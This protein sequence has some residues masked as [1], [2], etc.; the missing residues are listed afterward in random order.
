[1]KVNV[2]QKDNKTLPWVYKKPK[3]YSDKVKDEALNYNRFDVALYKHF[4]KKLEKMLQS[5]S[6]D[7]HDEV[8][9]FKDL[10]L[11]VANMCRLA[12]ENKT[13]LVLPKL[14]SGSMFTEFNLTTKECDHMTFEEKDI[15][16]LNRANQVEKYSNKT[17]R[18]NAYFRWIDLLGYRLDENG[19]PVKKKKGE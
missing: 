19:R 3:D 12:A 6:K 14:I 8:K 1:M 18:S 4:R 10:K 11:K 13:E 16:N 5:Q 9:V 2:Y 7:F 17:E 15:N